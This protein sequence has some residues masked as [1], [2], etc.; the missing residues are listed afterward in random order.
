MLSER[1]QFIVEAK[2]E[3]TDRLLVSERDRKRVLGVYLRRVQTSPQTADVAIVMGTSPTKYPQKFGAR[4]QTAVGLLQEGKVAMIIFSGKGDHETEDTDQ[5]GEALKLAF[6]KFNLDPARVQ[7]VGGNNT[8]ENL[9]DARAA[10]ISTGGASSIFIISEHRHLIR[11]L[12]LAD[13]LFRDD[14]LRVYPHPVDGQNPP[15]PNDPGVILEIVKA[16]C[17]NRTVMRPRSPI[18]EGLRTA[19]DGL[20]AESLQLNGEPSFPYPLPLLSS[21]QTLTMPA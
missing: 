6:R 20:V 8:A 19:I 21:R 5:A 17:Y 7:T 12:P 9:T 4:V 18:G 2:R 3:L 15:D 13:E 1:E 16:I 14:G 10:I 11:A